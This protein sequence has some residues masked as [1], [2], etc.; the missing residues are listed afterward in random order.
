MST[1]GSCAQS[2][3]AGVRTRSCRPTCTAPLPHLPM[4]RGGTGSPT[5]CAARG[6]RRRLLGVQRTGR[7]HRG[8]DTG[9]R[10]DRCT[11]GVRSTP[12]GGVDV[13][14]TRLYGEFVDD[15]AICWNLEGHARLRRLLSRQRPTSPI[16]P[17]SDRPIALRIN[18]EEGLPAPR[19]V[20]PRVSSGP[21]HR[22]E[23]GSL[24]ATRPRA[25]DAPGCS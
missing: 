19:A 21:A 12:I 18:Q 6:G 24:T 13:A 14:G 11:A 23:R 17:R 9:Q 1:V 22:T 2:R 20:L 8:V 7:H 16:R 15:V 25:R 10:G 5:G 4:P 3:G